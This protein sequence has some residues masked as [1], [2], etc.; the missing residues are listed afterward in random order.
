MAIISF[1]F[2]TSTQIE[3]HTA[4]DIYLI[5]PNVFITTSGD[6]IDGADAATGKTI[7]LFGALIAE[8]GDGIDLGLGAGGGNNRVHLFPGSSIF[9]ELEGIESNGGGLDLNNDGTIIAGAFGIN[10]VGGSD[11]IVNRGE[12]SAGHTGIETIGDFARITNHG[13][14]DGGLRGVSTAGDDSLIVNHGDIVST[15]ATGLF[16]AVRL[17]SA[18]GWTARLENYGSISGLGAI[19]SESGDETIVNLGSIAGLIELK[20][21][22]DSIVNRGVIEGEVRLGAGNDRF[23]NRGGTLVGEVQDGGGDDVYLIDNADIIIVEPD[24][25]GTDVIG[26]SVSFVLPSGVE[27][28]SLTGSADINGGGND[29]NNLITANAGANLIDGGGGIDTVSY[30]QAGTGVVIKLFGSFDFGAVMPPTYIG[31]IDPDEIAEFNEELAAAAGTGGAAGDILLNVENLFGSSANDMLV[32]FEANN[33]L[34]G[35]GGDDALFGLQGDDVLEGGAGA[36][37]LLGGAGTNFASYANA[38]TGLVADLIVTTNN[39]GDAAG[40]FY[41]SIHNLRGSQHDD[42]LLGT[43][44]TNRVEGLAGDDKLQGRGGGDTYLGGLGNDT[45]IFQT[46]FAL[47]TVLDFDALNDAEKI[48]LRS[49]SGITDFADLF[50]NHLTTNG[51]DSLITDGAGVIRLVGVD[52]VD[53]GAGDFVF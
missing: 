27:N 36:D 7:L 1:T 38:G 16:S 18:A 8:G 34:R 22:D 51:N 28:L 26:S 45:F 31:V 15:S 50:N 2:S 20:S 42:S 5:R 53:L 47:E 44:G 9:G 35:Q 52:S 23:D 6:A 25:D 24:N 48:N 30:G 40:D 10:S 32:G 29:L 37:N 12:I 13:V 19:T 39:T 46:G 21:G 43:F 49:V 14:I 41:Q 4:G 33:L 3:A 11:N 17:S